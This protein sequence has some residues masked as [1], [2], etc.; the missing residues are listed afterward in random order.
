MLVIQ[1]P[2]YLNNSL[3]PI[4]LRRKQQLSNIQFYWYFPFNNFK[5][6]VGIWNLT[7]W[8]P[9]FLKVR[10]Q[11]VRFSNGRDYSYSYSPNHLE[12]PTI[13][14]PAIFVW[15]SSGFWQDGSHLSRFQMCGP[16]DFRSYSKSRPFATQSGFRPFK[17]QTSQDFKPP[18]RIQMNGLITCPNA[19]WPGSPGLPSY[20]SL[21]PWKASQWGVLPSSLSSI[22]A[23]HSLIYTLQW[24]PKINLQNKA[25]LPSSCTTTQKPEDNITNVEIFRQR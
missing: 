11:M 16:L 7:I 3:I 18:H 20:S 6:T 24:L 1:N 8:N 4:L 2:T 25:P 12:N 14:N 22:K 21:E 10:F 13:Q 5:F 15:I 23:P 19:G 9:E 17:I